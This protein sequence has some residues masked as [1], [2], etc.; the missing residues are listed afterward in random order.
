M[1]VAFICL[2]GAGAAW[3]VKVLIGAYL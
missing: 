2:M 1:S 3:G